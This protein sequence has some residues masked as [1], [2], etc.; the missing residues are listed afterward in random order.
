MNKL[1]YVLD[2]GGVAVI[3]EFDAYLH[4]SWLGSLIAQFFDETKNPKRAQLVMSTHSIQIINQ[5]DKYQ[6]N[7]VENDKGSTDITRLDE[8]EGVRSV[9]D[10]FGNYMSGKYGG[11]PVTP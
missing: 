2:H 8:I 9:E 11:M 5:L 3:D 6:V 1:K 7:V 10:F 4:P